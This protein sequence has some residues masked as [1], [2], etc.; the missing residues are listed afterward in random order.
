MDTL[1]PIK[2]LIEKISFFTQKN[3]KKN[4]QKKILKTFFLTFKKKSKKNQKL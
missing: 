2:Q 4:H 3:P 1:G